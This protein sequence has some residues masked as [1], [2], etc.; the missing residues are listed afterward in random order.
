MV[1]RAAPLVLVALWSAG[2][3]ADEW[4]RLYVADI[5]PPG[6]SYTTNGMLTGWD[7]SPPREPEPEPTNGYSVLI[8]SFDTLPLQGTHYALVDSRGFVAEIEIG[9]T[10]DPVCWHEC[11][12]VTTAQVVGSPR[13]PRCVSGGASGRMTRSEWVPGPRARACHGAMV[14]I[15]PIAGGVL[16]HARV[17]RT[18]H[19][20]PPHPLAFAPWVSVSLSGGRVADLEY[21]FHFCDDRDE[22]RV[23]RR[24]VRLHDGRGWR[25]IEGWDRDFIGDPMMTLGRPPGA[26]LS[27]CPNVAG[28]C[29][30]EICPEMQPA[31]PTPTRVDVR[32][33]PR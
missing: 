29:E 26:P 7:G 4:P 21:G 18:V 20:P 5:L 28:P 14:A 6:T 25:E 8:P 10:I 30:E 2:P 9:V 13:R 17:L 16:D 23:I 31:R 33:A 32:A 24:A 22:H 12:V 27:F 3:R 1:G 19:Q 15:G 11:P